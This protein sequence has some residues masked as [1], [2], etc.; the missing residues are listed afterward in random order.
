[1]RK[2]VSLLSLYHKESSMGTEFRR[3]YAN[4][5]SKNRDQNLQSLLVTSA[6]VG[7]GKSL[8]SSLL[9]ITIAEL[10]KLKVALVDFDMRRP[11]IA[12]YFDLENE[13]GVAD[14]LTG[15]LSLKAVSR[16]TTVPNLTVVPAGR[17]DVLPTD[18]LEHERVSN[19]FQELKFYF[20]QVI[21]D[22]P[23]VIPVSDPMLISEHVDGVIMVV[24]GG[25]T[26]REVVSRASN[27]LINAKINVIGVVLNDYEE[28]LPY[29]YKER[30]YG[31]QYY[32]KD[33]KENKSSS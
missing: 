25:S 3:L 10:T 15:K 16:K 13:N 26:Q 27:L 21:V 30:Y 17:L 7:E 32:H 1:M 28:V 2:P 31:Y 18:V 20:D 6:T 4:I 24:R 8:T 14:V 23:P 12:Q 19:F 11:R 22:S 5:K 33:L 29:Y 9:A